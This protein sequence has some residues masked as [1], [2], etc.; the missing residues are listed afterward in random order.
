MTEENNDRTGDI[1]GIA[2]YGETLK[3]AVEKGFDAAEALLSRICIPAAE[4]LGLLFKDKVSYWRLN[5]IIRMLNKSSKMIEFENDKL[6][7]TAHPRVVKEIMDNGSW[8]DDDSL[9][10]MWAGLFA[11]STNENY[12]D[13]VNLLFANTLKQLTSNQVKILNYAC[14]NCEIIIDRNNLV[15]ANRVDLSVDELKRIAEF[16]HT[17]KID[18]ELDYLRNL[19]LLIE[20]SGFGIGEEQLQATLI[21]SPFAISLYVKCKGSLLSPADYFNIK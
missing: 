10:E 1:L 18:C 16:E 3:L 2:P 9:Q 17:Y 5:N 11:S 21:P 14:E 15:Y 6:Q 8:C 19:E 7:L 13:D 12:R 4:E 20:G